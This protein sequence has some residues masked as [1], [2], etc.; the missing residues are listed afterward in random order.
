MYEPF[1]TLLA[2]FPSSS[3]SIFLKKR[4]FDS[5]FLK[6]MFG[7][8]FFT[9]YGINPMYFIPTYFNVNKQTQRLF[10]PCEAHMDARQSM[11]VEGIDI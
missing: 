7:L 9:T 3:N 10:F 11:E 5:H 6:L 8:H 1:I 4:L 2:Y